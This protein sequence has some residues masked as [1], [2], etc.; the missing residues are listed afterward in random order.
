MC[1]YKMLYAQMPARDVGKFLE[2][3]RVAEYLM[4]TLLEMV[5]RKLEKSHFK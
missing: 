4:G 2:L 5:P 3:N 1:I